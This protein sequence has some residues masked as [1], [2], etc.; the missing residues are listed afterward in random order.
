[1]DTSQPSVAKVI[2]AFTGMPAGQL[3]LLG[4]FAGTW[5][6]GGNIM[7]ALH[8]RRV[9]KHWASGFKSFAFPFKDFNGQERVSLAAL[10]VI[11][12]GLGVAGISHGQ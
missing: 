8:Y 2:D 5:L 9:D 3:V 6:I 1:M 11:A 10:A 12:M 7:I 4:L